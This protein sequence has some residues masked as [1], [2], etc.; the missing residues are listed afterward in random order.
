MLKRSLKW[1]AIYILEAIAV[2]LALVIF[3]VGA[4]FWRLASGP[5]DLDFLREDAQTFIAQAFEG[6]VVAL[7]ELQAR[8]DRES[9]SLIV[10]ASDITVAQADGEVVTRAP[11]IEAGI[12]VNALMFGRIE[13]T[14]VVING[15]SISFVRRA[16]GAVGAGLGGV[17]RVAATARLPDRGGDD[18]ASLFALLREPASSNGMI[19][20]LTHI[21]I[22]NAAVR[23]V[24]EISGIAWLVDEAGVALERSEE[25]IA[26]D[27]E[28]RLAT[29]S[30]FASLDLRLE[31]GASLNSLLLQARVNNL[32]LASVAPDQGPLSGLRALDAPLSFDIV[33]D[34]LR[35]TGIRT[36]SLELDIGEGRL[37]LAGQ[38]RAFRGG[39]LSLNFDP[40][41]GALDVTRGFLDSDVAQGELT[42]RVDNLTDYAGA[43]P[44]RGS[45]QLRAGAGFVDLGPLFERPPQ[46]GGIETEGTINLG[47]RRIELTSLVAELDTVVARLAGAVS[48]SQVEDG[49][50][51]PNIRLSGPVEGDVSA[52][53]VLAYWPVEAA[54]GARDWVEE[55]ILGGRFFNARVDMDI[56]AE[57]IAAEE[58]A[59]ERLT[60]SF[61][62][63]DARVRYI[64]TMSPI[65]R[66][67]GRAALYGN[68]FMVEMD[69]G[70]IGD[71]EILE[72]Y[73][74][75]PR[76]NPKGAMARYGGRA[77]ASAEDLLALIDEEP[78]GFP[79]A[80]GIDP[81]AVGGEGEISFEIRRAML[82]D[83][84]PEDVGF[85]ISGDFTGASLGLPDT[86]VELTDGRVHIEA[87]QLGL[88][89]EGEALLAETPVT[90]RWEE[91][92][93]AD[94][95][96]PS[97]RF[98][99]S[100]DVG[101]RVLDLFGIPARRYL[102][103][104][105]GMEILA[106]S[107]GL[108][109]QEIDVDADLTNA[110]LEAPGSVWVKEAGV[111]GMA[112]FTLHRDVNEN[113]VLEEILGQTEGVNIAA[114]AT[115]A[116]EGRLIEALV[117][118]FQ[119]EGFVD[120]SGRLAAP[121]EAGQPFTA[122]LSGEYADAREIIPYLN[123]W[124][125]GSAGEGLPLSVTF[126]VGRLVVSDRSV[127]QDF[128][129][130]WRSEPEGIRAASI[131]GRSTEGPFFANFDAAEE[132]GARQFRVET[133]SIEALSAFFGFER[134]VRGG[135][136]SILGEAPPLGEDGP[137]TARVEIR[138]ITL[139]EVPV[140]ARILAAGSFE[141]L[142]ALLNGE[143]IRFDEMSSDILF[144]DQLL[145]LAD[146]QATG[147]S[148]GV[149]ANGSIDFDGESV[150][151]DGN[152][153]PSYVINS[154]LGAL[155]VVGELLV[156]RP[157]EGII[158]ITYSVEGPFDAMTVF[159]NPLSVLAPGVFRRIFEGTAAAR[160]EQE[161]AQD[162][163]ADTEIPD[164]L[165]P[166]VLDRL[167]RAE[168]DVDDD[169]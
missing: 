90:I 84:P 105:V 21:R 118:T 95:D 79:T 77:R 36:A 110:V 124:Q 163:A 66:A 14:S 64:S 28:G 49:R 59:N 40:G 47:E 92:F 46:W 57:S 89:A 55:G 161:R 147:N 109:I 99:A 128:S 86:P 53:T 31:A 140:L 166:E 116:P 148:L 82:T 159:A 54:D 107:Q 160:A 136:M 125:G 50:W 150:A 117:D 135:R 126:D 94:D 142:A 32:T 16:D 168:P 155:P 17:E 91:N 103:G 83:V 19:G 115:I 108:D 132:G 43:I 24:D 35:D 68:A 106:R 139:V 165:P 164:V 87:N 152:L 154:M 143:G 119:V 121:P 27:I 127:L 122:R 134:Y 111:P 156:S 1:S 12:A 41:E 6:E 15:G 58:L 9:R 4:V 30:G 62:F 2:L 112:G 71:I 61:D 65:T 123:R 34:A 70:W 114:S 38:E 8:Y 113:F 51:L 157:G 167:P 60:L 56:D 26:L 162:E 25:Q 52:E 22:E 88:T 97:T 48:L 158:G 130:I 75:M 69:T 13:P 3:G 153:A 42:G 76:L 100:A 138:D 7:G 37:L 141:G 85:D 101:V 133:Q 72:G 23:I 73:V 80:Y 131:S 44:T 169:Q 96:A 63:E 144:E 137:L 45:F 29:V 78:L 98:Q 93:R 149:T 120:L 67:A 74:D 18:S 39:G 129:V 81:S 151:L 10:S 20:Q 145:T 33:M 5:V 11:R 146:A 102:N 104:T